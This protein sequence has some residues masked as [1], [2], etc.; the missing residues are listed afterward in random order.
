MLARGQGLLPAYCIVG[1]SQFFCQSCVG[2]LPGVCQQF[3]QLSASFLPIFCRSSAKCLPAVLPDICQLFAK[4]LPVLCQVS[5]SSSA[6]CL[7]ELGWPA[8]AEKAGDWQAG[9]RSAEG[10][11]SYGRN[12]VFLIIPNHPPYHTRP[13]SPL[14]SVD[15]QAL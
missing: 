8:L 12:P 7:P 13:T 11:Q 2:P 4:L 1:T 6:S 5:A 3:C 14:G 10:L 15:V 9:G